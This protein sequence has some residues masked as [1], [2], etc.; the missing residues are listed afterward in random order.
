VLELE[1]RWDLVH[2]DVQGWERL[3]CDDARA[4]LNG[5]VAYL[6]VGTHSRKLDGDLVDLFHREGWIL[7][8][9]KPSRFT[10]TPGVA[11]LESMNEADGTQ[12]WRNPRLA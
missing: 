9:E 6:I 11:L 3:I 8:H 1:E 7:E 5:R 4:Q 10:F 12:V 2:I